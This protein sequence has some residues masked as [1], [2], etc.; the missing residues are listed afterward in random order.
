[1][2]QFLKSVEKSER[3]NPLLTA[4]LQEVERLNALIYEAKDILEATLENTTIQNNGCEAYTPTFNQL[5][6][7]KID[8]LSNLLFS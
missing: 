5:N 6:D 2:E 8:L 7:T 1:M 4:A 3:N